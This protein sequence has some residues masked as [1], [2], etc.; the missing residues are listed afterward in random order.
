MLLITAAHGEESATRAPRLILE[1][2]GGSRLVGRSGG[3]LRVH[4]ACM[5][6]LQLRLSSIRAISMGADGESGQLT[7][8]NG[9]LLHVRLLDPD[10]SV[11]TDFGMT[12][13]PLKLV[14]EIRVSTGAAA[15]LPAGLAALWS[16]DG[17][18][19]DSVDGHDAIVPAGM[20]YAPGKLGLGFSFDGVG[21]VLK[22]PAAPALDVGTG[23]G[24]SITCWIAPTAADKPEPLAEWEGSGPMPMYE[25]GPVSAMRRFSPR[26]QFAVHWWISSVAGPVVCPGNMYANLVDT[27][28]GQHLFSSPPGIIR[29]GVLQQVVLTYDKASGMG[30]LYC[31]GVLV[32]SEYLGSFTPKTDTGLEF[33]GST[34]RG[35]AYHYQGMMNE[36]ALF[37]RALTVEEVKAVYEAQK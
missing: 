18:G 21:N 32:K 17:N 14:R 1:L 33:G 15:A 7:A 10:L 28:G 6:D 19:A 25:G 27:N 12:T 36:I 22:V 8:V 16:G 30:C 9:D 13:I 24:F 29:A 35:E 34:N 23:P 26:S 37:N 5:G 20:A 2:K 31:D 3:S 4:S 11:E